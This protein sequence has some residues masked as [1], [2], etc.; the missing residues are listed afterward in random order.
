MS[1]STAISVSGLSKSYRLR[2]TSARY[3]LLRD[4]IAA[5]CAQAWA[6]IRGRRRP[7]APSPGAADDCFWALRDV[8]FDVEAGE[9]VGVIGH[10]GAGKSTLLK[11]L[12]RITEPTEGV[13]DLTGRVGS[14]LEVG[15]GFH[16]ELTG[17]ENVFLSGA[18]LGMKEREIRRGF[19]EIVAFAEVERFID[20]PVKHYSSG[21]HLRLAFAVAAHLRPEILLIDE[22][23]AVGDVAFQ[24]KCL[25]KMEDVASEG[26]TVLFVSHNLGAVKELCRTAIVLRQGQVVFH[27]PVV[28]AIARYTQHLRDSPTDARGW[29]LRSSGASGAVD[30]WSVE[31]GD[32][33]LV[34]GVLTLPETAI[35]G[36]L[37]CI[38]EDASGT[39]AVHQRID[40]AELGAKEM[41]A[42]SYDVALRLPPL[43]LAPGLYS[44]HFKFLS[45]GTA[46]QDL[47]FVSERRLMDVRGWRNDRAKAYLAPDAEWSVAAVGGAARPVRVHGPADAARVATGPISC[48]T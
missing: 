25:G 42:G 24:R 37:Y 48:P 26:R 12:A 3:G 40:S 18:I 15:T 33:L 31:A 47:R 27:G 36:R 34:E 17:R 8:S 10:N 6:G 28:E 4:R 29:S 14:L 9:S 35:A 21:M 11:V 19:D 39:L 45:R 20:T 41:P 2:P 43:W 1:D 7:N 44:V 30:D 23:L 38:V 22:V 13:A 32:P 16:L 46:G 5:G